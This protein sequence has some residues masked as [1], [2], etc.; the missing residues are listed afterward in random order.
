MEKKPI[1]KDRY[2]WRDG[3]CSSCGVD[4]KNG[5]CERHS[6]LCVACKGY[7]AITKEAWNE[8][9]NIFS[10][11]IKNPPNECCKECTSYFSHRMG[12]HDDSS[13]QESCYCTKG[14]CDFPFCKCHTIKTS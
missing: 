14:K 13:D 2:D 1:R 8:M 9:Q 3:L 11:K 5:F 6:M 10:E 12:L 4:A 7:G